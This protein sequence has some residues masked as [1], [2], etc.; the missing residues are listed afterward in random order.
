[1]MTLYGIKN[2]DTVKKALAWLN[3]QGIDH[4][5][6]DFRKDGLDEKMLCA[7]IEELGWEALLNRR[8]ATWRGLPETAKEPLNETRAIALMIAHPAIIKRPVLDLGASR[9]VGFSAEEYN[10]LFAKQ[11]RG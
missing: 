6:H 3:Q 8:G 11:P 4:Q 9:H 5:F 1:M 10:V 2:C 7:W